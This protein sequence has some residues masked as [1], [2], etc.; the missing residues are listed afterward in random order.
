MFFC[1]KDKK[2]G[3]VKLKR[4]EVYTDEDLKKALIPDTNE[5]VFLS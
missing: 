4:D 5:F 2:D 1:I 3:T